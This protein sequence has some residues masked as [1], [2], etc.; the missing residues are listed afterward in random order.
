[1]KE[2]SSKE[3]PIIKEIA[4]LKHKKYRD[5]AGMY[6][7]EGPHLVEEALHSRQEPVYLLVHRKRL[8]Q[9]R[10][11][12]DGYPDQSWYIVDERIMKQLSDT[13]SP[14]GMLGVM[15]KP[16]YR[17]EQV[18]RP[19][20]LL[21]VLDQLSDPGNVGTIIR[22]AWAFAVDA[23]L[24]TT[25]CVDPFN[26]KVV[27]GAMGGT[28]HVPVIDG[29]TMAQLNGLKSRGYRFYGTAAKGARSVYEVDFKGSLAVVIGSEARGLSPEVA[30]LCDEMVKIPCKDGVDSLNAA[31]ACGIILSKSWSDRY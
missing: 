6:I 21:V 27:R 3:N 14:Q 9:Y 17:L 26:P 11:I 7:L 1:M 29:I 30:G 16:A 2:I 23:V 20:G 8:E 15:A 18:A 19:G 12:I 31:V 22:T 28:L 25:G 10:D 4:R 24:L 13:E 5:Q